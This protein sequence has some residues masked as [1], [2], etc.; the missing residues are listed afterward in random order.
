MA[1]TEKPTPIELARQCQRE[2][3]ALLELLSK[4]V[5]L[6]EESGAIRV[7]AFVDHALDALRIEY[8]DTALDHLIATRGWEHPAQALGRLRPSSRELLELYLERVKDPKLAKSRRLAQVGKRLERT[9]KIDEAARKRR[10][11]RRALEYVERLRR[12]QG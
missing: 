3:L 12:R 9:A 5:D 4:L 8:P 10:D 11:R 6:E 7:S 2:L 1:P